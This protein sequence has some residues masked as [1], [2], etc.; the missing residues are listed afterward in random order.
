M[1]IT[2]VIYLFYICWLL[3]S[4]KGDES[5]LT[6]YKCSMSTEETHSIYHSPPTHEFF[7]DLWPVL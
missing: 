4:L 3:A 1:H 7:V 2:Y 5:P 6:G